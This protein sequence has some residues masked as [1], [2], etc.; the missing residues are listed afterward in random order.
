MSQTF[1]HVLSQCLSD[2]CQLSSLLRQQ[3]SLQQ[4]TNP[5]YR[6]NTLFLDQHYESWRRLYIDCKH[7]EFMKSFHADARFFLL[8]H[9]QD[10]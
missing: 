7:L 9:S 1:R 3:D 4:Q 6:A 5:T 10:Q 8:Q 2:N